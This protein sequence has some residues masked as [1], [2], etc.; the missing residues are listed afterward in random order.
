MGDAAKVRAC[1]VRRQKTDTRD[2]E[3]L[4][5]LLLTNR[6]PRLWIPM[7]EERDVRQLLQHRNKL[8]SMR[9]SVKNQLHY[10]AMNQGVCR[11]R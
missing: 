4:L 2:A 8:V 11:K 7:P 5:D 3:H 6:F 1:V 9:T 10:L